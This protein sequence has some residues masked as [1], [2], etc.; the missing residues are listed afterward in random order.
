MLNRRGAFTGLALTFGALSFGLAG[1]AAAQA[2]AWIPQGFTPAQA[3]ALD[4]I[5]ELILPAT[6]TPGA[7][8]AGVPQ[9]ID[10]AVAGWCDRTQAAL[11]R[12][13][14]DRLDSDAQAAGGAAFADLAPA[15]QT[16][17][18]AGYDDVG[19]PQRPFF[20]SLRE[21]VTIGYFT[22][23]PGATVALRYDPVPGVYRSCVPLKEIG[24]AWA[25]T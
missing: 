15:R 12:S 1:P 19:A 7:R 5:A 24:R 2:P 13:G 18:V 22:S 23:K 6:D 25:T 20:V 3:R 16:S 4:A 9:F 14:L 17:I 11:L 10:R 8:A 21:L